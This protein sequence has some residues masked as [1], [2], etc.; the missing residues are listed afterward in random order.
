MLGTDVEIATIVVKDIGGRL[1]DMA[2][3]K[4]IERGFTI[5]S[6]RTYQTM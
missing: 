1:V 4:T 2:T 5:I 6:D 3:Q